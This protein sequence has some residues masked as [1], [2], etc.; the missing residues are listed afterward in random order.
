M[1]KIAL[2]LLLPIFSCSTPSVL[3]SEKLIFDNNQYVAQL[4]TNNGANFSVKINFDSGF[5]VKVSSN[6]TAAKQP[7]DITKVDVYLLKLPSGFSGTDPLGSGSANVVK[8]FT[9]V[10][11]TGSTISMTFKNV[12]GLAS[13]NLY[14]V[15][16]VAKDN[17][18]VIS[19]APSTA[20][21]GQT[22]TS[23]PAMALSS[24][25]IGVDPTTLAVS[26]TGDISVNV[27][28]LDA[29]GAQIGSNANVSAGSST[30]ND[31]NITIQ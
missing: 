3:N 6:G 1:K 5:K 15:G 21:T 20:W 2:L 26:S 13:P 31:T 22:L 10:A 18:S 30:L 11:K 16:V 9:D 29:V 4:S 27:P 23:A 14:W 12:P 24:S 7:N 28:L 8:S 19:K 17:S 25:G